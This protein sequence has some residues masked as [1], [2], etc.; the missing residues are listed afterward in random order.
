MSS[1]FIRHTC[2]HNKIQVGSHC[3]CNNPNLG[4]RNLLMQ[5][6]HFLFNITYKDVFLNSRHFL[7]TKTLLANLV[8][9]VVFSFQGGNPLSTHVFFHSCILFLDFFFHLIVF[10]KPIGIFQIYLLEIHRNF[11][12]IHSILACLKKTWPKQVPS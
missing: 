7:N 4:L 2:N 6:H 10:C 11:V 8:L 1:W 3:L 12:I 9:K 5:H